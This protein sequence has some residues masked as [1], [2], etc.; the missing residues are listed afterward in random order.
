MPVTYVVADTI[1][2]GNTGRGIILGEIDAIDTTGYAAGTEI[3]VA[4]GGGWTSTRPTGTAII[5]IL[6]IVTKEG[7][8]GKGLVLNPGPAT[9]PNIAEGFAWVGN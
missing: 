6:G 4:A 2:T 9:L 3:Y 5:Q 8:G 7:A 1:N